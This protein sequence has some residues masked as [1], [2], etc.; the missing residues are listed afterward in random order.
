[1][2]T[3]L[4]ITVAGLIGIHPYLPGR[5]PSN[6]DQPEFLPALVWNEIAAVP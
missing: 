6:L 1:M 2:T 3:A 5:F 4:L